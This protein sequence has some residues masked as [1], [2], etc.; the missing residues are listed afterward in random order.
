MMNFD[1]SKLDAIS[2]SAVEVRPSLEEPKRYIR[3][4]RE[5]EAEA[6]Q[7]EMYKAYQDAIIKSERL[8]CEILKGI[9][10]HESD[11]SLLL[12]SVEAIALI[13]GDNA[14][15]EQAKNGIKNNNG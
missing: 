2:E 1:L 11:T 15:Y 4:D 14:F 6:Q 12:K 9:N 8:R 7:K 3:I 10:N 13:T 5:R